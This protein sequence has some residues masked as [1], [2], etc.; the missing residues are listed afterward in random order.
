MFARV[1]T[2]AAL[3]GGVLLGAITVLAAPGV[4]LA[5]MVFGVVAGALVGMWVRGNASGDSALKMRAGWRGGLLAGVIVF[6]GSLSLTG[7]ILLLGTASGAVLIAL[8]LGT[9][10]I[11]CGG[12]PDRRAALLTNPWPAVQEGL[13]RV[14]QPQADEPSLEQPSP[15][16]DGPE[17]TEPELEPTTDPA[18][19]SIAQLCLAWQRTYFVL[20][21]LPAGPLRAAVVHLRGVLL[22]EIERRDPDGFARWLETGARAGSDPR[23]YLAPDR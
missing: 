8:V 1:L 2:I 11:W 19:M 4:V 18:D 7:L 9:F 16:M 20:L 17:T 14:A 23:R 15:E 3:T 6:G 10:A 22:D 21:D 5:G 13:L 12:R